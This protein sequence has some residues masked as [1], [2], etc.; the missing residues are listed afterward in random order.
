MKMTAKVILFLI[1]S[2]AISSCQ[3]NDKTVQKQ[4]V[5]IKVSQVK[6]NNSL[7]KKEF[8]FIAKPFRSSELSFRVGGPIDRLEVYAGNF[9]KRGSIIAEID[10]RDFHIRK[11]QAEAVYKQAKAEFERI[12]IL[13][14]KNNISASTFE[15]AGADYVSAKTAYES[16]V[17]NLNDTKL[18]APFDG[19]VGEVY[20]EK[21][22]DIKA[23]QPI[24]SFINIE[25]L[26]I[27][28]YVNQEI[29]LR[30]Q[31]LK[32]VSLQFD[33]TPGRIYEA[34]IAEIS[35]STTPN[36]LSYLLTALFQNTDNQLPAGMSGKLFLDLSDLQNP[37]QAI[38][39]PQAALCHRPT[40]GDYVWAV[41][42][43]E[44][45]VSKR[46]VITGHLLPD[47]YISIDQGLQAHETIA[48]S[49]L[50]FLSEGMK[51]NIIYTKQAQPV[52][53][54]RN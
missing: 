7:D 5:N 31:E 24:L 17:N 41:N 53:L 1:S 26:R 27:E 42:I 22:Q 15:K 14:K 44:Q 6:L 10:P 9:Y 54:T 39:I 18:I 29:A 47:G 48:V 4:E 25:Q 11:E 13:H 3:K 20:I 35:K 34:E 21:F 37:S 2:M 36:N 49:G 8:S 50:R 45:T 12:E 30:G 16:A 52:A 32:S 40:D 51:V 38:T 33:A 23:T 46:K 43:Q 19:Y 28:A